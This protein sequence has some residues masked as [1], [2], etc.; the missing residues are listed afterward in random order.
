[1]TLSKLINS[2]LP[3]DAYLLGSIFSFQY[4][5]DGD[6]I[7]VFYGKKQADNKME[8]DTFWD[9]IKRADK[10][11]SSNMKDIFSDIQSNDGTSIFKKNSVG[12]FS[13]MKNDIEGNIH[14]AISEKMPDWNAD[15]TLN[16]I[17][18]VIDARSSGDTTMQYIAMDI[19]KNISKLWLM[20]IIGAFKK[21]FNEYVP[22]NINPRFL[23]PS[24]ISRR[25]N[26]QFRVPYTVVF[27]LIGTFRM[28]YIEKLKLNRITFSK[29]NNSTKIPKTFVS[30]IIWDTTNVPY[31]VKL[32]RDS[33][34]I[35]GD[36]IYGN[37][38]K[39]GNELLV[40]AQLQQEFKKITVAESKKR[41]KLS[42]EKYNAVMEKS[43]VA[44][45]LDDDLIFELNKSG[46]P[47]AELHHII[48][49][50][51][52]KIF[53]R[54]A[55]ID[56]VDNIIP[57]TPSTHSFLHH[58]APSDKKN[59][60]LSTLYEHIQPFLSKTNTKISFSEFKTMY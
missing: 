45:F 41:V 40:A 58:G 2:K 54:E 25:K 31:K 7:A 59:R 28:Q 48:P 3:E 51:Y 24:E 11:Y 32:K 13:R 33:N 20:V 43:S 37:S 38:V 47:I 29:L 5:S 60:M 21:I 57:V 26:P 19:K 15:Y 30:L 53:D 12:I 27:G 18:G 23:S 10:Y 6:Y 50:K 56:M 8:V 35:S 46:K 44:D 1:M 49:H 14:F 42:D 4:E 16:F 9:I 34:S 39:K 36:I 22:Y 52:Y 17:R 55:D